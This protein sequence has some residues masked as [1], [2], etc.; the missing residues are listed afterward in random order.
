MNDESRIRLEGG[1]PGTEQK[2]PDATKPNG[3][4]TANN[5]H[6]L[7]KKIHESMKRIK[8]YLILFDF[9]D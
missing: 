7:F 2:I 8:V 1:K 4:K 6:T 5:F 9:I 3:A